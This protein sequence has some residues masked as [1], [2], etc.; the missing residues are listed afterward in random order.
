M[1]KEELIVFINRYVR[2]GA[3]VMLGDIQLFNYG[4]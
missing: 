4:T 2:N 1:T 3:G